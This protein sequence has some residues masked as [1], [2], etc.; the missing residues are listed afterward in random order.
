MICPNCGE[1]ADPRRF[2]DLCAEH[3][4]M[5]DDA[6]NMTLMMINGK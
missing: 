2:D 4:S 3:G 1:P 6:D 5:Q